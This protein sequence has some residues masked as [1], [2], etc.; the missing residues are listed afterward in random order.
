MGFSRPHRG[1]LTNGRGGVRGVLGVFPQFW[2]VENG[3]VEME[4][5]YDF[6]EVLVRISM[7][8]YNMYMTTDS[9]IIGILFFD[10]SELNRPLY[11]L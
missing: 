9:N 3:H 5:S 1:R 7:I 2:G 6:R 11:P 4:T 10:K 8:I